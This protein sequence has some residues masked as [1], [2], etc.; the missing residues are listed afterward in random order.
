[1]RALSTAVLALVA[2][3]A[4]AGA[5]PARRTPAKAAPP[6]P[7]AVPAA[8]ECPNVLGQGTATGRTFCDI[9]SGVDPAAGAIIRVPPHTGTATVLFDLH[10]RHMYS[11]ELVASGRAYTR[12]TA[13]IG[14]LA[15]NGLLL[16][17]AVVQSEFR[18]AGDLFD[19][20][21][22]AGGMADV[23]A[24][25][26]IG[27]EPIAVEVPEGLDAVSVLGE[28]LVVVRAD[29]AD[30]VTGRGRPIAAI[31]NVRVEYRPKAGRRR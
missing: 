29:G 21:A 20:I 8:V 16:S 22:A 12:A 14:V 24:V 26:P 15:M 30:N 23:K 17:R 27:S 9:L 13:T 19:R 3:A 18:A 5:Q 6:P 2:L 4:H 31:S 11:A 1:M 25:A 10:N 28:T 7:T